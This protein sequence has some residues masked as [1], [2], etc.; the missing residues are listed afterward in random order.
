MIVVRPYRSLSALTGS[1]ATA[2]APVV[3]ETVRLAWAGDRL[4]PAESAGSSACVEYS[5][6]KVASPAA[7]RARFARRYAGLPARSRSSWGA[8]VTAAVAVGAGSIRRR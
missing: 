1:S 4:R 3:A 7:N 2:S 5:S 6:A 8:R